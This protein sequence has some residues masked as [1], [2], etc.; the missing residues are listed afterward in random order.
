MASTATATP[1][2][3]LFFYACGMVEMQRALA[4]EFPS[5]MQS[6]YLGDL[7]VVVPTADVDAVTD[8]LYEHGPEYGY[9]TIAKSALYVG[10]DGTD[11]ISQRT[12]DRFDCSEVGGF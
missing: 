6:A 3:G 9:H 7:N 2:A 5:A 10:A 1:G 8:W 11:G 4:A 12:L